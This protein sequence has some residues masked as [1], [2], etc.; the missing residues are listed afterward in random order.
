ML[1][2]KTIRQSFDDVQTALNRRGGSYDLQR[3]LDLNQQQ[4]EIEG[5]RSQLQAR[6]NEIGKAVGQQIRAGAEPNGPEV[7]TLRAEG[8]EVNAQLGEQE[9]QEKALKA[10]ARANQLTSKQ[11]ASIVIEYMENNGL[12]ELLNSDGTC[13]AV[14]KLNASDANFRQLFERGR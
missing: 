6:S 4:R 10:W 7:A 14:E 9:P 13:G 3:V 11:R 12:A 5:G 1:D 8:N 2:L